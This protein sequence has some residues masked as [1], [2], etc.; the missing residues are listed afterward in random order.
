M[1]FIPHTNFIPRVI[2]QYGKQCMGQ[3]DLLSGFDIG[4]W[5]QAQYLWLTALFA[6]IMLKYKT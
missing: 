2:A 3:P 1:A 6:S 4:A 5:C